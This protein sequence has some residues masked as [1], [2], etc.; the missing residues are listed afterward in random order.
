MNNPESVDE[1]NQLI[2][3]LAL[4]LWLDIGRLDVLSHSFPP[5]A[6]ACNNDGVCHWFV[7]DSPIYNR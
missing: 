4:A 7:S 3:L 2:R 5:S 1:L 6:N